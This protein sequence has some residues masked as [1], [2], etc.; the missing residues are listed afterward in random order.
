MVSP[1]NPIFMKIFT[2]TRQ[3]SVLLT[4]VTLVYFVA[5]LAFAYLYV[6]A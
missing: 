2:P 4:A 5:I 6:K 1:L 3:E